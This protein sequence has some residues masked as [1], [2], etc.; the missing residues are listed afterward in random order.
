[1][2]KKITLENIEVLSFVTADNIRGGGGNNTNFGVCDESE[3][4]ACDT[5]WDCYHTGPEDCTT[6]PE[7][8]N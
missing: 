8:C 2:K 4:V 5:E 7:Y 1:M 6:D 3:M